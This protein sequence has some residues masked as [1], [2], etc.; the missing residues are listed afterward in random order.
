MGHERLKTVWT[1]MVDIRTARNPK[2]TWADARNSKIW[3]TERVQFSIS[4]RSR[5]C[6]C[7]LQNIIS[8]FSPA[9]FISKPPRQIPPSQNKISIHFQRLLLFSRRTRRVRRSPPRKMSRVQRRRPGTLNT[10]NVVQIARA[11]HVWLADAGS[12]NRLTGK[13]RSRL[14]FDFFVRISSNRPTTKSVPL[15]TRNINVYPYRIVKIDNQCGRVKDKHERKIHQW[16]LSQCSQEPHVT[17]LK[18]YETEINN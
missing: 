5:K 3:L 7:P 16:N 11:R 4:S 17:N 14:R 18:N 10:R 9:N 15:S 8:T 13:H 12:A 2:G 1:V 6:F